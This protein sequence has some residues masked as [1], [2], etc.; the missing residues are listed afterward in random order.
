V[1]G[2]AGHAGTV[3]M[4][5]RRDALAAAAECVLAIERR[6][7]AEPNLVGTVGRL[8]AEPGA[9]NVIPGRA[10]FSIDV[11]APDDA[12]RRRV[13]DDVMAEI[14][15]IARRRGVDVEVT[16]TH[17]LSAAPCAPWLMEQV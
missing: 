3:P 2:E 4:D 6:C 14:S 8:E 12:Q 16:K 9:V 11:R 5:G 17:E 10:R 15:A 1:T 7:G 13:V